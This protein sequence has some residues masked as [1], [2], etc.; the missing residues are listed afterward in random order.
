VYRRRNH[1]DE[2]EPYDRQP[3]EYYQQPWQKQATRFIRVYDSLLDQVSR[4][5]NI[6]IGLIYCFQGIQGPASIVIQG[7]DFISIIG[8]RALIGARIVFM[9]SAVS[10][11]RTIEAEVEC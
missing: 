4:S 1:D 5:T 11:Q 8:C 7:G 10:L 6:G 3:G 2:S 9:V